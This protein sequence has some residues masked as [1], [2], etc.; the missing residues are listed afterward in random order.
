MKQAQAAADGLTPD[1]FIPDGFVPDGLMPAGFTPGK[2]TPGGRVRLARE[3]LCLAMAVFAA[4]HRGLLT[5]SLMPAGAELYHPDGET[6]VTAGAP[7]SVSDQQSLVRSAGNQIRGAFALSALQT[8]RE[9]AAIYGDGNGGSNSIGDSHGNSDGC[10]PA[11]AEPGVDAGIMAARAVIGLIA[12]SLRASLLAP[13]WDLPPAAH[14]RR[15]AVPAIGFALDAAVR[16]GQEVR[17]EH[18][19]GLPRYLDLTLFVSY[20]LDGADEVAAAAATAGGGD[21]G[22]AGRMAG[23][24]SWEMPAQVPF[25]AYLAGG[26]GAGAGRRLRSASRAGNGA[27]DDDNSDGNGSG[28]AAA[29]W[30]APDGAGAWRPRFGIAPQAVEPGPVDDFVAGA[31]ATGGDTMALAGDLYTAYAR[32]CLDNGYLAHSQ[33]KFGLELTARGYQRKRRGKGRHWW[34]GVQCRE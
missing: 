29:G 15:F 4:S 3:N 5:V 19:G 20:C 12:G 23:R 10:P 33:R 1:G 6:A 25:D 13:V 9:L 14:R 28:S 7:P 31:C 2:L 22:A 30:V 21:Y 24:P 27:A 18:F 26:Y 32:W 11:P 16:H 8:E 17:W 34:L